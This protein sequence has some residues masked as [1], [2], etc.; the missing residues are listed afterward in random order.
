MITATVTVHDRFPQLGD[1]VDALV[2]HALN[3][4]A[5]KA[6]QTAHDIAS[7]R[8]KTGKMADFQ[9]I[10]AAGDLDGFTAGIRNHPDAWYDRFQ[11]YGTAGRRRR[12][13]K[14]STL[15]HRQS[16]SGTLR[17]ERFG[18][19]PGIEPLRF[20]D[21]ARREGRREMLRIIENGL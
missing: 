1:D 8:S 5:E 7:R 14:A 4:G 6:A 18:Q 11:N 16:R 21:A 19:N 3:A 20:L 10:P 9:P 15:R 13:L 12:K 2:V 17:Q